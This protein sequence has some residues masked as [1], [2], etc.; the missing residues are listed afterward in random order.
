VDKYGPGEI[1]D[2]H[3]A[4]GARDP[5]L[6]VLHNLSAEGL[7][8]ADRMGGLAV[9]SLGVVKDGMAI[10]GMGEI[11][12]IGRRHMGDPKQQPIFDADAYTP[13]FP[14]PEYPKVRVAKAQALVDRL[15][16]HANEF[17]E[18][19][20]PDTTLDRAVNRPDPGEI[21]REWLRSNSMKAMYLAE[22]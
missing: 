2:L 11:T 9:P 19:Y 20:V 18:D 12:L 7:A 10:E 5:K 13:R 14:K 15:R 21:I 22:Q 6:S 17:G 4:R 16:S 3:S 8:F 1:V